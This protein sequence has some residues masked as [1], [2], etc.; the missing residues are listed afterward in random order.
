M[1]NKIRHFSFTVFYISVFMI[2]ITKIKSALRL[3]KVMRMKHKQIRDHLSGK[4][5]NKQEFFQ[6]KIK[7]TT[8][9]PSLND[10]QNYN[11]NKEQNKR[12]VFGAP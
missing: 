11:Q 9:A 2:N 7:L 12:Q 10:F 6:T 1:A 5:E 3:K 8:P 4:K